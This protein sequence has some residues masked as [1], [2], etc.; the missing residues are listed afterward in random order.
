MLTC[1]NSRALKRVPCSKNYSPNCQLDS[2]FFRR[3]HLF[4]FHNKGLIYKHPWDDSFC[5]FLFKRVIRWK[6][7]ADQQ[8]WPQE[9]PRIIGSLSIYIIQEEWYKFYQGQFLRRS[10]FRVPR[11]TVRASM[12]DQLIISGYFR[13]RWMWWC[14]LA[15]LCGFW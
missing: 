8:K 2:D 10:N 11:S 9:N 13:G 15:K 14:I 12:D 5:P 6:M 4:F 3:Q 1:Y 7:K